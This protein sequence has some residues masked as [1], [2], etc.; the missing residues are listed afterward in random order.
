MMIMVVA[1]PEYGLEDLSCSSQHI[2]AGVDLEGRVR[3]ILPDHRP[4]EVPEV[5]LNSPDVLHFGATVFFFG[6]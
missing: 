1:P 6:D 2:L 4:Q 3:W 5:L